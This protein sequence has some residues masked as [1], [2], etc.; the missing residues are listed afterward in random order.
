LG[1]GGNGWARSNA[2][3][4]FLWMMTQVFPVGI[5]LQISS[6]GMRFVDMK[7]ARK[8]EDDLLPF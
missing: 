7:N 4:A 3:R 5:Y 6:S 1:T 2:V 8:A